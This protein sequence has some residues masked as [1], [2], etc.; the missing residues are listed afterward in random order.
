MGLWEHVPERDKDYIAAPKAN[1]YSSLH[2][3]LRVPSLVV[4]ASTL[5]PRLH[6][7]GSQLGSNSTRCTYWSRARMFVPPQAGEHLLFAGG[8]GR[9]GRCDYR[10]RAGARRV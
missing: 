8:C 5:R 4:E 9:T 6:M 1:G 3:T 2:S 10:Q 7:S